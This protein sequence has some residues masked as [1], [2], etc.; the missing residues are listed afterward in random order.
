[1]ID[2]SYA[3]VNALNGGYGDDGIGVAGTYE[4]KGFLYW[5]MVGTGWYRND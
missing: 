5:T 3:P 4:E 1:L 2:F